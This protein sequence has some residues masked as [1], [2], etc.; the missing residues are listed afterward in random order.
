VGLSFR[1]LRLLLFFLIGV[2]LG[3]K[4]TGTIISWIIA[5]LPIRQVLY[6]LDVLHYGGKIS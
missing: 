5:F 2:R 3:D 1:D 6:R 4:I